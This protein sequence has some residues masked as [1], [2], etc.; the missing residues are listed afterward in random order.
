MTMRCMLPRTIVTLRATT[1]SYLIALAVGLSGCQ[2]VAGWLPS[3]SRLPTQWEPENAGQVS[4]AD[5]TAESPDRYE[6]EADASGFNDDEP[7][8]F[9]DLFAGEK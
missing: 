7:A 2:T 1:C 9:A 8:N 4:E 6:P 3:A 5:D